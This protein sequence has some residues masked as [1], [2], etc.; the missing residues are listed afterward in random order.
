MTWI[1]AAD[2][3]RTRAVVIVLIAVAILLLVILRSPPSSASAGR[4]HGPVLAV[5]TAE[6]G[7]PPAAADPD[8]T[9]VVVRSDASTPKPPV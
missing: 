1:R 6:A 8:P 3:G 7:A 9:D 2:V 4:R 5:E